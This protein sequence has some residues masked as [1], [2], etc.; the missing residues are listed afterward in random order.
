[1]IGFA[2]FSVDAPQRAI[3]ISGDTVWYE[4]VAEVAQ[5]FTVRAALLNLGAARVPEVGPYHLTMTASEGV[6]AAGV[7]PNAT[8]IPLHFEGWAHFSEGREEIARSFAAAGL[9]PRLCWPKPGEA[10]RIAL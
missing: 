5:R 6:Q 3:Y 7:F 1:V 2:L 8:I 10:I 4:G 9:S